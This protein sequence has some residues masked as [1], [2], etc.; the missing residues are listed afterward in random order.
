VDQLAWTVDGSQV[1]AEA[2]N[3]L[4][5]LDVAFGGPVLPRQTIP[6]RPRVAA[7]LDELR[8]WQLSYV[9]VEGVAG[10]SDPSN[11][12]RQFGLSTSKEDRRRPAVD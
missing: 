3:Q 11:F 1:A 6:E 10:F 8:T 2:L 12:A 4:K 5:R 9:L 7:M